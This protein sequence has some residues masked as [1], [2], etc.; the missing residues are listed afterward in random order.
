MKTQGDLKQSHLQG[1]GCAETLYIPKY[2]VLRDTEIKPLPGVVVGVFTR[3]GSTHYAS[4]KS[5]VTNLRR[6][7]PAKP[8]L[9]LSFEIV[10]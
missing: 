9:L 7:G 4:V 5:Y 8:N 10:S 6:N 2:S 3:S 1:C